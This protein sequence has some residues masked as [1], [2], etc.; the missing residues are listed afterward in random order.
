[1]EINTFKMAK[2]SPQC[3]VLIVTPTLNSAHYLEET[4]LSVVT[5]FGDFVIHYHIQDGMSSDATLDIVRKWEAI[6]ALGNGFMGGA[7]VIFSWASEKDKSMYDSLNKGF[8]FLLK[9]V[10]T[11]NAVLMTW[12]NSDDKLAS[13]SVETVVSA[14]LSTGFEVITG[15]P[16][17]IMDSGACAWSI[18]FK[19]LVRENIRRGLHDGRSLNFIMQEGTYW[20]KDIWLKS[21]GLNAD[22][23]LA[24]DWDLWRRL[25][26]H[27][28]WLVV[29]SVLAWHRRHAA[30][31]SN[32]LEKYWREVDSVLKKEECDNKRPDFEAMGYH[33]FINIETKQWELHRHRAEPL[34]STEMILDN[35]FQVNFSSPSLLPAITCAVGLSVAES[36]GCWSDSAI[37]DRVIFRL[38]SKVSGSFNLMLAARAYCGGGTSRD[39]AIRVGDKVSV[40]RMSGEVEN[41]IIPFEKV[42]LTDFITFIPSEMPSPAEVSGGN[43]FRKL[44]IGFVSLGLIK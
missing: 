14:Y 16:S 27:G 6:L 41:Y 13:S 11:S 20:T 42:S 37:Y 5:Q 39:V 23:R 36:W 26:I 19:Q 4:I 3:R 29:S 34:S 33:G 22:L 12:I 2:S 30:Q 1:M 18:A 32:S 44:G 10:P 40:V 38:A 9:N 35:G 8:A 28:E 15:M 43:D 24:G 17:I 31:L 21:G 25:A 7:K